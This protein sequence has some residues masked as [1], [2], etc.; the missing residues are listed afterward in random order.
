MDTCIAS[1]GYGSECGLEHGHG[2]PHRSPQGF[3]WWDDPPKVRDTEPAPA[4][5][6]GLSSS[7]SK[8]VMIAGGHN[9]FDLSI[10]RVPC[11]SRG[12]QIGLAEVHGADGEV[13]E[14]FE[15]YDGTDGRGVRAGDRLY[16]VDV[17]GAR[18]LA[19]IITSWANEREARARGTEGT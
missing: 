6:G 1:H 17:A 19:S 14:L 9:L 3:T 7:L 8:S 10:V 11:A 2:G 12:V 18:L 15:E 5:S 4:L 13:L 16:G